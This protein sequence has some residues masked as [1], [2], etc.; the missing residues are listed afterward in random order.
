MRT[1]TLRVPF[2][3]L[4]AQHRPLRSEIDAAIAGVIDAN[5][6][7]LGSAVSSFEEEFASFC[8]AK[9]CVGVNSGTAALQL[10]L[11]AAGLGPGDE[12]ITAPNTFVATV[13]AITSAGAVPV[14][15]DVDPTTWQLDPAAVEARLSPRTAAIL[16]VHLYG[17]PADLPA[18]R[19][20][21]ERHGLLLLEDAAQAHGA[22][23]D[24]RRVGSGSYAAA[25]SFYPG[26]NLGAFGDGGAV[27]SD[28][29]ALADR[30]VAL[31]HHGQA[32][33]NVH[34]YLGT[35]GRLDSIQ[36]AVLR[37]KLAHLDSWNARRRELAAVYREC[38][39]DS[40]YTFP[41]P[42]EAAEP[43]YHLFVVNHPEI[44]RVTELLGDNGV[45]WGR[46][47]PLAVH[48]QPAFAH[49]G[50]PGEFPVA[51]S[52]C[53]NILSLPMFPELDPEVVHQICDLLLRADT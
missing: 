11:Q 40:R 5:A 27:V 28:D 41:E 43:V 25:F 49:L 22:R 39:A 18:F 51:E 30:I 37:V 38:L 50:R 26:K 35:T 7:I 14:L 44:D 15:A 48:R 47:Y 1:D 34:A 13:E 12:V 29:D 6:F 45:S 53:E 3:D 23:L 36:A 8:G 20:L 16:P 19:T 17:F 46:H 52:I 31:R 32:E 24:G 2:V 4:A 9:R 10:M 42:L 33:K 21:A